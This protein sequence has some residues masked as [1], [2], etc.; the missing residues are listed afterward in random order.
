MPAECCGQR[1]NIRISLDGELTVYDLRGQ[2]VAP[3]D[4]ALGLHVASEPGDTDDGDSDADGDGSTGEDEEATT[5]SAS[6]RGD[7]VRRLE[8]PGDNVFPEGVAYDPA[9]DRVRTR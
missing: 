1:V 9:T 3:Q 8:L 4:E 2:E 7:P 6:K 5:E